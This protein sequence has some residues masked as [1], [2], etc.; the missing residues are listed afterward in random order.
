MEASEI[1]TPDHEV[2][3]EDCVS[4]AHLFAQTARRLFLNRGCW[5][6]IEDGFYY[7]AAMKLVKFLARRPSPRIEEE[8][9]KIVKENFPS[10]VS[11]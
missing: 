3:F 5:S 8:M 6:A 9:K 10:F 2:T 1:V 4:A 7:D 11:D